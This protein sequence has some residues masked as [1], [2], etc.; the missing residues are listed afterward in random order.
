MIRGSTPKHLLL[1][2]VV[3]PLGASGY[4]IYN[5]VALAQA[6]EYAGVQLS[7]WEAV[8]SLLI[9]NYGIFF[10]MVPIVLWVTL[11]HLQ[12][13]ARPEVLLRYPTR[14][15]WV[16]AQ[17][18]RLAPAISVIVGVHLLVALVA[19]A[20]HPLVWGWGP[21]SADPVLLQDWPKLS[22]ILPLPILVIGLQII[23]VIA[24][25]T[26]LALIV[27]ASAAGL[28]RPRLPTVIAG[29]VFMW[30]VLSF[31]SDSAWTSILG[32]EVYMFPTRAAQLLDLGPGGGL[33][34]LIL[35]GVGAYHLARISELRRAAGDRVPL[36]ELPVVMTAGCAGGLLLLG[37][38][39]YVAVAGDNPSTF[40]LS[41]LQGVSTEEFVFI[42][43]LVTA[44]LVFAPAT[45][46]HSRL[47][48]SFDGRSYLEMIRLGTPGRWYGRQLRSA[49]ASSLLYS[50]IL[51]LWALLLTALFT[52]DVP[53]QRSVALAA[54]WGL[55][56]CLQVLIASVALALGTVIAHRVEG[57]A[58][59]F[60]VL[61][62]GA[63][64]LGAASYWVPAGHPSLLR[65]LASPEVEAALAPLALLTLTAWLAVLAV[66]T[67]TLFNRTRAQ[68][69]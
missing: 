61:L 65:L 47:I 6:E 8:L 67:S 14:T 9:D 11:R 36:R 16:F 7:Y 32:P 31:F 60:A 68:I 33:M 30:G 20:G 52:A 50:V 26:A 23:A 27:V 1:P 43:Y 66:I 25:S 45:F 46:L 2:V 48:R 69:L 19:A 35:V 28:Q 37:Y 49:I 56:L 57:G 64:P 44:L 59:A 55:A 51:A 15:D 63:W 54:V 58:Y 12:F 13:S 3:F 40:T 17:G 22:P 21:I 41:L 29:A 39:G 4:G 42:P 53:G 24:T 38:G 5:A 34:V 18:K 62:V 10:W